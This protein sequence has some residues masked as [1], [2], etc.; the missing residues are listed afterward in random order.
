MSSDSLVI[1]TAVR[2]YHV[3][4]TVWVA[5]VGEVFVAL[6]EA[7]NSSDPHAMGVYAESNP[8][9]LVGHLPLEISRYCHYFTI[10]EGKISGEV[11]GPRQ[12]SQTLENGG[13]EI[14]CLLTFSGRRRN[15]RRLKEYFEGLSSNSV[16]VLSSST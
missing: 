4:Q 12:Y 5:A 7:G 10:H 13:M 3:Y 11:S 9:V 15:I 14:P 6:H 8:G 1:S 16:L 2:G